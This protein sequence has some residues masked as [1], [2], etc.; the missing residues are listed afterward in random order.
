M[1]TIKNLVQPATLAEAV[2]YTKTHPGVPLIAGGTFVLARPDSVLIETALDISRLVPK[3]YTVTDTEFNI[4]S[5]VTFQEFLEQDIPPVFRQ[6]LSTM[7]NRNI[8]NRA[9][10]GGNIGAGK[11]CASLIPLFLLLDAKLKLAETDQLLPLADWLQKPKG[12]ILEIHCKNPGK[13]YMN[14]T[15]FRRTSCDLSSITVAVSYTLQDS[16]I[17]NLAIALDGFSKHPEIRQDIA[18][19]FEGKPLPKDKEHIRTAVQPLLHAISDQRG[20][21]LYKEYIGA[22]KIAEAL[23]HAEVQP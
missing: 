14:F 6:A 10:V 2:Q 16:M 1:V 7:S 19:L 12:I 17:A 13:R 18:A 21:N 3:H 5:G 8:R 20:S 23:I 11:S 4:G 15:F 9:T 22:E